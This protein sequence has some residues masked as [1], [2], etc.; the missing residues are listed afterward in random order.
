MNAPARTPNPDYVAALLDSVNSAPYLQTVGFRI[1]DIGLDCSRM[2][3]EIDGR[4]LQNIGSVHGG[5]LASLID[6]ATYWATFLRL[7]Q[8]TGQVNVDLKLNYLKPAVGGRIVAAGRCLRAGR[9]ISYAECSVRDARG[10]LLAHGTS[11][12]MALPG[13]GLPLPHPKFLES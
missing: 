7:P 8:D 1:V 3:M 11:T 5:A 10:E 2:E 6:A 12:L 4:Q 13:Q 9:T